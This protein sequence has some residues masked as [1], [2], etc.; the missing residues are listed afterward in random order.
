VANNY[1]D[2]LKYFKYGL[3]A[4]ENT[5]YINSIEYENNKIIMKEELNNF[6]N[7]I[8]LDLYVPVIEQVT[9]EYSN[10]FF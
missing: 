1:Q 4:F 8:I 5:S 7:P 2:Q 6:I 10:Y 3:K 9:V